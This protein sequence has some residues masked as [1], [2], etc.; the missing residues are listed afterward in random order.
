MTAHLTFAQNLVDCLDIEVAEAS[1]IKFA[2]RASRR[3]FTNSVLQ[4][5]KP[6]AQLGGGLEILWQAQHLGQ[7]QGGNTQQGE[8]IVLGGG[9]HKDALGLLF[10]F[11][12][13]NF[14]SES[15]VKV[16]PGAAGIFSAV[17]IYTDTP[18]AGQPA[19]DPAQPPLP[20]LGLAPG[21]AL[22]A[23]IVLLLLL[24]SIVLES[25]ATA[26]SKQAKDTGKLV[27][28]LRACTLYLLWFVLLLCF[29]EAGRLFCCPFF[30]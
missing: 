25:Y 1:K 5:R 20:G 17:G 6:F 29:L 24:A 16:W 27:I 15:I 4:A 18:G 11:K 14:A 21:I 19:A 3:C 28:F 30:Y 9:A 2:S 23:G 10:S 7:L 22:F 26:L 8:S 13:W 12:Y